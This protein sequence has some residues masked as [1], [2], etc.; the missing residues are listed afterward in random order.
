MNADVN[1]LRFLHTRTLNTLRFAHKNTPRYVNRPTG[2]K[3][4]T[5]TNDIA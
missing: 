4:Y 5:S 1:T 3:Q 2:T